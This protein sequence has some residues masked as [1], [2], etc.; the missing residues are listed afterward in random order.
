MS[1]ALFHLLGAKD[2]THAIRIV[3]EAN[4][5][6]TKIK[7]AAGKDT[8]EE[9]IIAI[10]GAFSLSR[11]IQKAT[12]KSGSESFGL[13]MAWQAAFA[14]LPNVQTK[15]RELET[16][17]NRREVDDLIAQATQKPGP[18]A[19]E[20]AGKL[21]KATADHFREKGDATAL[22]AFLSVAPRMSALV[23]VKAPPV[24]GAAP[25]M[26]ATNADGKKYEDILPRVRAQ[27]SKDDAPL[28]NALLE[29]WQKRGR[30]APKGSSEKTA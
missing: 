2:E 4:Q 29:D 19:H 17:M 1:Q 15:V 12:E 25:L 3:E 13:V 23:E 30:P 7:D 6:L 9:S 14:E 24:A 21:V 22:R 20:H 16:E 8:F 10:N 27:L 26:A 28:Y 11:D 18:G 5:F